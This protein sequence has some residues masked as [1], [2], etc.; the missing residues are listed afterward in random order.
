VTWFEPAPASWLTQVTRAP[1]GGPGG[2]AT[3]FDMAVT[4]LQQTADG[5]H[6]YPKEI[7]TLIV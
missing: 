3:L 6:P 2:G 7:L 1:P 5:F 4:D